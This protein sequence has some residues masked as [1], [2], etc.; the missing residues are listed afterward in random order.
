MGP[1]IFLA[2][3][4]SPLTSRH[5]VKLSN[6]LGVKQDIPDWFRLYCLQSFPEDLKSNASEVQIYPHLPSSNESVV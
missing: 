2:R 1:P 6:L 5:Y 4:L 3:A